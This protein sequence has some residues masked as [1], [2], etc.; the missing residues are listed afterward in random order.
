MPARRSVANRPSRNWTGMSR[1]RAISPMG[2][3][4][5]P[6]LRA[7]SA[8]ARTAYGDFEVIAS[9]APTRLSSLDSEHLATRPLASAAAAHGGHLLLLGAARPQLGARDD[10][11]DRPED[12]PRVGVR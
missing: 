8:S 3:G 7:S 4:P 11:P 10:R 12:H 9:T 1:R 5:D 6:P 2:T